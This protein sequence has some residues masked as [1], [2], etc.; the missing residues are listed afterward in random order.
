VGGKSIRIAF[1]PTEI[2]K[3]IP[4]YTHGAQL[5][6]IANVLIPLIVILYLCV[7]KNTFGNYFRN[8]WRFDIK[9]QRG[10]RRKQI[11]LQKFV[12]NKVDR[13]VVTKIAGTVFVLMGISFFLF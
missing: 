10:K 12:S 3:V 7:S 2:A 9:S 5:K 11:I 4:V 1:F 6:M 13:K 8:F